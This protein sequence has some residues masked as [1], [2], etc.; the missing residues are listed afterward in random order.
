MSNR[1]RNESSPYLKQHADNPVNWY[2]WCNEAFET[3]K[4]E[5]KPIFLSIGYSTCHWCHVM[6]HE[7]FEDEKTA[8][9]LNQDFV[10]IK[11]DRE[12][13]PDIDS[14]YMSVCQAVTGNGGW[15]MSIFMT[16][17]KKP[18][19]AGTYFPVKPRYGMPGFR[20]ILSAITEKWNN[21]REGL[22]RSADELVDYIKNIETDDATES[23]DDPEKRAFDYFVKSFDEKKGG[24][25]PAPKFPMPHDIMFLLLRND[26]LYMAQK[27][28]MQMRKGGIFDHIGGG[29]SRYSTDDRYL[30]PHFEK[31]LYDNAL[32]II[33]YS[34]AF[35]VTKNR[36]YLE[37]AEKTA[38]YILNE[39]ISPNNAFYSAQDADSEGVEGRYYTFSLDE[40][41]E[42]LNS[43]RTTD[44]VR[45]YDITKSGN[46]ESVN[47]PNL[48]RSNII[49]DDFEAE[50]KQ[51][52]E[53]RKNRMTLGVD[54]KILVSWNSLM[55]AAL[56]MLYRADRKE[57]Y[58]EAAQRAELYIYRCDREFLD[59]YAFYTAALIELYNSTLNKVYLDK[60][61]QV[62]S[63][64]VELF[65]DKEKGGFYLS[66]IGSDE[67]FVNPKETYDGAMPSGNSVMAYNFVR[68]WQLTEKESYKNHAEDQIRYLTARA[69]KYPR[70]CSMFL[71][72][73]KIFEAPPKHIV[74]I[75]KEGS[76]HPREQLPFFANVVVK[77]ESREYPCI[78][79]QTTYYVCKD[80]VCLP[81]TNTLDDD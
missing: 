76:C 54:D 55:I 9:L 27:T 45:R 12:Q 28:L 74:I 49:N 17:D 68:L 75:P 81:P 5:D 34:A 58:L 71:I 61:E 36:I 63:E 26:G 20:D 64:A 14:V 37:T 80:H 46:F 69:G 57:K 13:R 52:Y 29:F 35:S 30:V 66:S 23:K 11:V 24:F 65:L 67:L 41:K 38:D 43:D 1:L 16:W 6:A 10:S 53:Y 22:V 51:L 73:K 78:N 33:A 60:A 18:F 42:V 31:M 4:R 79:E 47:I 62:C 40:V 2:P 50:I 8:E 3:A 32:L 72:A 59:D 48:L 70:G 15:P 39:M 25:G 44:F 56:A 21:D 77:N 19:F 7:S